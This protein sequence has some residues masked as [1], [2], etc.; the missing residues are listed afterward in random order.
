MKNREEALDWYI[1]NPDGWHR[2][3]SF[4]QL[5]ESA[6]GA[7]CQHVPVYGPFDSRQEARD[8]ED[9]AGYIFTEQDTGCACSDY[10]AGNDECKACEV[11]L[12]TKIVKVVRNNGEISNPIKAGDSLGEAIEELRDFLEVYEVIVIAADG[13]AYKICGQV[14]MMELT[15]DQLSGRREVLASIPICSGCGTEIG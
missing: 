4:V 15:S 12:D 1:I 3:D 13:R 8:C 9:L 6:A 2:H 5:P 10:G 11:S 14:T 7:L